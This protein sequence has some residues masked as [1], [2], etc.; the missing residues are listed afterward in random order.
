MNA[1]LNERVE[2]LLAKPYPTTCDLEQHCESA[3]REAYRAILVPGNLAERAYELL[4]GTDV[5][6]ACAI[7]FPFGSS[8]PDTK[9]FETEAAV[10]FGAH[11]IELVPSIGRLLENRFKEVLREI[12]DIVEAA[13]ERPVKVV[14]ESHLWNEEQLANIAQMILDSGAH[15]LSTSIALQGRH[16]SA[17]AIQHLRELIGPDFGLKVAGLKTLDGAEELIRSGANR[18]GLA[19][20][21]RS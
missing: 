11:E 9:R 6:L 17:E 3:K 1:G 7:G 20:D 19:S 21:L 18:I 5:K 12:R 15:F 4:D 16:S 14:I 10:D 8:D 13:D 2:Y